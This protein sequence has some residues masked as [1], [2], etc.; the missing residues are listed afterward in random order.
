MST[1]LVI[2]AENEPTVALAM[3]SAAFEAARV[4]GVLRVEADIDAMR[5]IA[6]EIGQTLSPL[7]IVMR[8]GDPSRTNIGKW[9]H[10]LPKNSGDPITGRFFPA[11]YLG[12]DN[13]PNVSRE[14]LAGYA[15]EIGASALT[16]VT[17]EGWGKPVPH[18]WEFA[19]GLLLGQRPIDI[20]LI[21]KPSF[22]SV[23]G[24]F[25][26]AFAREVI[27]NGK[28][29]AIRRNPDMPEPFKVTYWSDPPEIEQ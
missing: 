11:N 14:R 26:A 27:A 18:A 10:R 20:D 19:A 1:E 15:N 2:S 12:I 16:E 22:L 17:I 28:V 5:H 3:T 9:D 29:H 24:G 7:V 23:A 21:S 13:A 4:A 25:S 6:T 8:D